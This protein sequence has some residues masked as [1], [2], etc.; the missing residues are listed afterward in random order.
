MEGG[1]KEIGRKEERKGR[2]ER[3]RRKEIDKE[4]KR[5]VFPP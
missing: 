2:R 1:K 4:G 5:E 3:V